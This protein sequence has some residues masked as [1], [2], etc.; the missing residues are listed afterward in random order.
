MTYF[1]KTSENIMAMQLYHLTAHISIGTET[2]LS[3]KYLYDNFKP[4]G[5]PRHRGNLCAA[6]GMIL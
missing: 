2:V 1:N 4:L 3:L 5:R 6:T